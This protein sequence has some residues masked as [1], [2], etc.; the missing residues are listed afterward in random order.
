[1][2]DP[3]YKVTELTKDQIDKFPEYVK[4]WVDIGLNTDECDVENAIKTIKEAYKIGGIEPP[5]FF[6]GPVN[7]PYEGALAE[8]ILN[9]FADEKL[10]FKDGDE[11][12]KM[13]LDEIEKRAGKIE[14]VNL[15]NQ[16]FGNSEYWI[17][18]IDYFQNE[19]PEVTGLD[20]VNPL[21]EL[22]N[23]IGMWTPLKDVAILQHRPKKIF[24]DEQNRLHNLNGYAIE[25]RGSC[26]FSSLYRI[27]GVAVT[28][29]I[30]DRDFDAKDIENES[31]VEVRRIMI[32]LYGQERFLTET[33]TVEV[34]RDDFGILYKKEFENDE[35]LMMVKVVNSTP[36]PDGSFKDYYIRVDPNA[37]G[38]LK[39]AKAA[40]S[41]TWRHKDGSLL[42]ESPD[43]YDCSIQT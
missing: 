19:V 16:V 11:L 17:S 28:K 3:E 29:K 32:D 38:G 23:Y 36:E 1:M 25:Y 30:I 14:N 6:I 2:S 8:K 18:Y 22:C 26:P 31:N 9:E 12:N 40:V 37:Y 34:H 4:K 7:S 41:S 42:F 20:I 35:P 39:T 15:W 10:N 5:K 33:N 24:R 21:K 43:E 13:V 27:H